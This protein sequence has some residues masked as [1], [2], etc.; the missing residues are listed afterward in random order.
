MD[1]SGLRMLQRKS[2]G[3]RYQEYSKRWA[4]SGVFLADSSLPRSGVI[5]T[6]R[7]SGWS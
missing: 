4:P 6:K 7:P 3:L 5:S 1:D 2:G